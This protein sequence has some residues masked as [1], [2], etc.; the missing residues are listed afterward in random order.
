MKEL[1]LVL[2]ASGARLVSSL[3]GGDWRS[4]SGRRLV[5]VPGHVLGSVEYVTLRASESNVEIRLDQVCSDFEGFEDDFDVLQV[6][7]ASDERSPHESEGHID[8]T[9][10]E[11]TI[12]SIMLVRVRITQ[13]QLGEPSW[14][15]SSDSGFVFN[16]SQGVV[17]VFKATLTG[18]RIFN[19]YFAEKMEELEFDDRSSE[20]TEGAELGE[21]YEVSR[22]FIPIEDLLKPVDD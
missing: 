19:I 12:Q 9:F 22:E 18:S 4:I 11:Q 20:W 8:F 14:E 16:L 6:T 3:V 5:E 7:S 17:G 15:L 2:D 1:K 13:K 21:V 10:A